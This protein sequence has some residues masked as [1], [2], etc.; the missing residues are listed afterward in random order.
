MLVL[1]GPTALAN[2]LSTVP[3]LDRSTLTCSCSNVGA[4][5]AVPTVVL[6]TDPALDRF[7]RGF[8]RG[9]TDRFAR[10]FA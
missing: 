7:A 2:D 5:A 6:S 3:T 9:V 1:S 8:A 10:G 4:L